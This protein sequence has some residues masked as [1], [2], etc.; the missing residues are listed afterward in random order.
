M[1]AIQLKKFGI[2]NLT[3]VEEKK[4]S[5]GPYEV[6][7]RVEAASINF[8]DLATARGHYNPSIPLPR[9]PISDGAGV[10]ESAGSEVTRW[11]KGDRVMVNFYQKWLS[12][13]RSLRAFQSQTGQATQGVLAE[14]T[15][16]HEE[17]LVRI[18]DYLSSEEASTLPIA[19][20]T[21]WN[22]L[23][24][25]GEL[26]AGQTLVTQGSGGV[27]VFALQLAKAAG[28]KVIATSSSDEKLDKLKKWG[29]DE[30]INYSQ[31]KEWHEEVLRLTHE[32]GADATLDIGGA[33]TIKSAMLA[34]KPHGFVGLVGFLGGNILPV[35]FFRAVP[36]MITIQGISVGSRECFE[37]L[38]RALEVS[39]LHP[40]ID[41]VFP[42][43]KTQEAYRLMESGK[44]SGKIVVKI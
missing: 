12:G 7:I 42:I 33:Q 23:F 13:K 41:T 6:L 8:I 26:K 21:A 17:A 39:R 4:P 43:E 38:V 20:V 10:V 1:K 27:S 40:V 5:P 3:V 14:Y 11:K 24:N 25:Y 36:F 19:G 22:G 29:A 2:E 35:D 34:V 28:V 15:C 37:D 18:P 31:H 44:F 30:L 9:I 16:I 32:E